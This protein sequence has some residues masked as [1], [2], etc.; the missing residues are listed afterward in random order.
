VGGSR[1]KAR[2]GAQDADVALED[3]AT[4]HAALGRLFA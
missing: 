2:C 1:L 3:L 4:A